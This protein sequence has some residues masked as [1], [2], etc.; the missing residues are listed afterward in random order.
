LGEIIRRSHQP[1]RKN[2]LLISLF[3]RRLCDCLEERGIHFLDGAEEFTIRKSETQA[4]AEIGSSGRT[5]TYN[6]PVTAGLG[7]E[8]YMCFQ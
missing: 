6:P 4:F 1:I 7:E 5:R 8:A 2:S 3:L